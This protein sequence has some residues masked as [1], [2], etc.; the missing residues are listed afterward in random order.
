VPEIIKLFSSTR[1]VFL[2]DSQDLSISQMTDG[3]GNLNSRT[4][5]GMGRGG[6]GSTVTLGVGEKVI[7]VISLAI[8]ALR[9]W[10]GAVFFQKFSQRPLSLMLAA[11]L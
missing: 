7:V 3:V 9:S 8:E 1:V 2:V 10:K 11:L 4:T 5:S 6:L